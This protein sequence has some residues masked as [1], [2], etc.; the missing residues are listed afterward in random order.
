M[1]IVSLQSLCVPV[2]ET[3]Q[4]DGPESVVL[5]NAHAC[6]VC[7]GQVQDGSDEDH[8]GRENE[9][10]TCAPIFHLLRLESEVRKGTNVCVSKLETEQNETRT[11]HVEVV[12]V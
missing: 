4:E 11:P 3:D 7:Q 1:S 6:Q 8:N 10:H 5:E 2:E 9:P 12:A